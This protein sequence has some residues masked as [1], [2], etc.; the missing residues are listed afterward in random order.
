M[1]LK[2]V[3]REV[4]IAR[5]DEAELKAEYEAAYEAFQ[6]QNDDIISALDAAKS[7]RIKLEGELRDVILATNES[8]VK[9]TVGVG[10]RNV[11]RVEY[12]TRA[13]VAFAFA[14][15]P[16]LLRLDEKAFEANMKATPEE[17]LP[18]FVKIV[19]DRQATVA[20]DLSK[21]LE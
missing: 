16:A 21:V 12:D 8:I 20:K 13:A 3:I 4:A 18:E 11:K 14:S 17:Y 7:K 10:I 6:K 15:A 9:D 1:S 2:Q 19:T 5:S